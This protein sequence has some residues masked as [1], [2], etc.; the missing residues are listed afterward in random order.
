LP[1]LLKTVKRQE[2]AIEAL[3]ARLSAFEKRPAV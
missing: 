1:D 2:A 3:T